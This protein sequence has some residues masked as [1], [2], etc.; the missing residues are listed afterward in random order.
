MQKRWNEALLMCFLFKEIL[1]MHHLFISPILMN[2]R[3]RP[4]H[5]LKD[6]LRA[7]GHREG[8][9]QQP[10]KDPTQKEALAAN[11]SFKLILVGARVPRKENEVPG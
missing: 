5:F 1:H 3:N 2:E 11:K 7:R 4:G 8:V 10:K 6:P 9:I